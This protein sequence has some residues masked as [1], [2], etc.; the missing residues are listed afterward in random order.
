MA[1]TH[2]LF[3]GPWGTPHIASPGSAPVRVNGQIWYPALCGSSGS[4]RDETLRAY[5][6]GN[7]EGATLALAKRLSS[8]EVC[9]QCRRLAERAGRASAPAPQQQSTGTPRAAQVSC[10]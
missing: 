3:N 2:Y 9:S 8:L 1:E 4:D 6:A 7:T 5:R 10:S